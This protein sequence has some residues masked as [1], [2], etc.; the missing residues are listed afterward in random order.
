M[1]SVLNGANFEHAGHGCKSGC[2]ASVDLAQYFP[3]LPAGV[4][5]EAFIHHF[6][7]LFRVASSTGS[8][9]R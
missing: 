5:Q 1:G 2:L 7:S 8:Q 4:M 6:V 9:R 3:K